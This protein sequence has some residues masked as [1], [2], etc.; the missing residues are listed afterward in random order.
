MYGLGVLALVAT[1]L[2]TAGIPYV[3]KLIFDAM[4]LAQREPD[5]SAADALV[6]QVSWWALAIVGL[7]CGLALCRISSRILIFNGGRKVEYLVRNEL[8]RHMQGLS[9]AFFGQMPVGDLI[10]RTTNDIAAVRLLG[11]P[12]VLNL[13]NTAIVYLTA[14]GPMLW[15]SPQLTVWALA[16]L[17]LI[18]VATRLVGPRIYRRSFEAQEKLSEQGDKAALLRSC[19]W[20][21]LNCC[22]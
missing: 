12:G 4:E 11:G 19:S 7:A 10:S 18:F 3:T 6:A 22:G 1:N 13:A 8:Y 5:S 14:V 20:T 15:I 21:L 16:P 9:P 2:C 17:L